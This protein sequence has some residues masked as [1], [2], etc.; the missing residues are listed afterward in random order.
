[1]KTL[2]CALWIVG[3]LMLAVLLFDKFGPPPGDINKAAVSA[4][5]AYIVFALLGLWLDATRGA[6]TSLSSTSA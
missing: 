6:K 4:L 1:M 5:G 3:A 2:V